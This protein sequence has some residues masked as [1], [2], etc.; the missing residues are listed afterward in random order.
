M[1]IGLLSPFR[2]FFEYICFI[3]LGGFSSKLFFEYE[4]KEPLKTIF[5]SSDFD[6]VFFLLLCGHESKN[7]T[8]FFFRRLW[9]GFCDLKSCC[10]SVSY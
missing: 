9:V 7:Q 3:F 8:H 4:G 1:I 2:F 5:F 10:F 6:G